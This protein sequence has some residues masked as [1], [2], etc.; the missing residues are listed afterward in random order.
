[1]TIAAM[2]ISLQPE[3][4]R[5]ARQRADLSPEQLR[6]KVGVTLERVTSW[7][8]S[9]ELTLS[10]AE[11]VARSTYT[12]LGYLFLPNP[13]DVSLPIADFR[14]VAGRTPNR[15][16]PELLDVIYSALQRQAWYRDYLLATGAEAL[17]FIGSLSGA[18]S[19]VDAATRIRS[20]IHWDSALRSQSSRWEDALA[21]QIESVEEAGVLVMRR[22]VVGNNTHRKLSVAEFRG[23]ALCDEY[24]PAVF[25]NGKDWKAAQMFTLAHEVVHLWL[26]ESGVSNLRATYA[27]D[28]RTE[29]FCNA[30]AAE[31]LVPGEE[32]TQLWPT[33][34]ADAEPISFLRRHFKV[35]TPV[36]LRRLRDS[37]LMSQERFEEE[38]AQAQEQ[39]VASPAKD[40]GNFYLTLRSSLGK[41]FVTALVE[42]TLEGRTLYRDA[43]QLLGVRKPETFQRLAQ[44]LGAIP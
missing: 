43:F 34:R 9:G 1:M 2:K 15:P 14:T 17:D 36:I 8:Q 33:A 28:I 44:R 38:Y 39:F 10:Q 4:L 31:L 37:N 13:P 7:E 24:A 29:R 22:G 19:P 20:V 12:P 23:F 27:P 18:E 5:W 32:L 41:R 26:G 40:G 16:S 6:E 25:L 42:S 30:V 21:L 35:S 3:L 11:R